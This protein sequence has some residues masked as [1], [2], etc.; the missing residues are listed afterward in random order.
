MIDDAGTDWIKPLLCNDP[1]G[2]CIELAVTG[3]VGGRTVHVRDSKNPDSPVLNF[4]PG[5]LLAF[6]A[7]AKAGQYDNLV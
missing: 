6:L 1:D 4:T 5:E 3:A 7:S 2:T